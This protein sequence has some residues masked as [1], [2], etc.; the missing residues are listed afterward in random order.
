M[1]NELDSTSVDTGE[2]VSAA[3]APPIPKAEATPAEI[4]SVPLITA[5]EA[6]VLEQKALY[7]GNIASQMVLKGLS[8]RLGSL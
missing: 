2:G 6:I 8:E 5:L 7:S 1:T 3:A 4:S